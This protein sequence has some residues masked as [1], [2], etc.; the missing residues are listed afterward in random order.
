MMFHDYIFSKL[1]RA[2]QN[3]KVFNSRSLK[4]PYFYVTEKVI[5]WFNNDK[6]VGFIITI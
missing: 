1:F 4:Y 5:N 2:K 3:K 6:K